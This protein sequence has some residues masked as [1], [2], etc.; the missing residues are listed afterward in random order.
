MRSSRKL[1]GIVYKVVTVTGKG[2]NYISP[3]LT[4]RKAILEMGKNC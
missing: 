1:A 4:S 2:L 3:S